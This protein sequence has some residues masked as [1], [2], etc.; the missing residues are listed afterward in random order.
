PYRG[1]S[2]TH[3]T[4][5]G[6]RCECVGSH[7]APTGERGLGL[8]RGGASPVRSPRRGVSGYHVSCALAVQRLLEDPEDDPEHYV[9]DRRLAEGSAA[10]GELWQLLAGRV[11]TVE[12]GGQRPSRDVLDEAR[13]QA[14]EDRWP[15]Q[16]RLEPR[17]RDAEDRAVLHVERDA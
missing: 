11:V 9:A 16:R 8:V 10:G 13:Q 6:S 15:G 2:W 1:Q 3:R 7:G 4:P 12:Q 14:A 17:V 5:I